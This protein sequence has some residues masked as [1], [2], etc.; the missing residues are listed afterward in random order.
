MLQSAAAFPLHEQ[1]IP[2]EKD[3][4]LARTKA[5]KINVTIYVGIAERSGSSGQANIYNRIQGTV[6]NP[7][8]LL[9]QRNRPE[10][11]ENSFNFE[12]SE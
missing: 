9:L 4:V 10:F 1:R 7:T 6:L 8:C 3:R 11:F 2:G 12:L 5:S